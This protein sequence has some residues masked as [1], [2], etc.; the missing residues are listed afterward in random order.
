MVKPG[1]DQI[2]SETKARIH[3]YLMQRSA[4]VFCAELH[5][6]RGFVRHAVSMAATPLGRGGGHE[7][8]HEAKRAQGAWL[9]LDASLFMDAEG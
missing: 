4:H 7:S 9:W 2:L 6:N 1:F 3:V 8:S 5:S